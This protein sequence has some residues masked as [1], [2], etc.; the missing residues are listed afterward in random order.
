MNHLRRFA[1]TAS[2][3]TF[4]AILLPGFAG[5]VCYIVM[6]ELLGYEAGWT[7]A[8]ASSIFLILT[9]G[10]YL[11]LLP[12]TL[13]PLKKIWQA[14]WHISPG[15][16]NVPA[17]NIDN[18]RIGRELVSSMVMQIY[19]LAS[20][21][22]AIAAETGTSSIP[23]VAAVDN[24]SLIESIPLSLFVLD[25][26]RI[27]KLT[28]AS[29]CTYVNL[30]REKIVGK[31]IYDILHM[32]FQTNDTL[33]GWLN[34]VSTKRATG[35]HSWEHIRMTVDGGTVRQFD[36]A[37]SFSKDS[38]AG[39][40]IILALFDRTETYAKQDQSASYVAIAVHEL[41][42][43]LTLLRG[44]VEVFEDELGDQLTPEHKEFMRKMSVAAQTLTAFVSNILNVARIDENQFTLTLHEASWNQMLPEIINDLN[45]RANVRGRAI[46]LDIQP[47][48]PTVA[49][50]KISMYE[51]VS[52][53]IDNAIKYGGQSAKIIVHASLAQDGTI[54]TEIQDFGLGIPQ[55]AIPQLFTKYY[56]SHRSK[57]AV[58]G[59][60]LG[61]FLVK[62]I[63]TAH[64]GN[65]WVNSKE[66]EGSTF[67]FSL[68]PYASVSDGPNT[69]E[70][71]GIERQASGWIKNH[72]LYRR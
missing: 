31:S 27:V 72:S 4:I 19:S 51:V 70:Q 18:L 61:L 60:G 20:H 45:L 23:A 34:D 32:S 17:P 59:S 54:K 40:E 65:V 39:N 67:G 37:A 12:V 66:G 10:S 43:P 62:S 38:S 55:S 9:F 64:G 49:I 30:P 14:I 53:L 56:R 2:G 11:L 36:I 29:S 15:K 5:L 21:G 69:K 57:N 26:D 52:N 28:N 24:G 47:D 3:L 7:I 50:D 33:D 41:R 1:Q 42:T 25:K 71:D 6:R 22:Q 16:T 35:T 46:E 63:V 68:Q 58:G 44:Y 48:L 13:T 8:A